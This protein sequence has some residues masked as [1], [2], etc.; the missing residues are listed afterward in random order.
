MA[1]LEWQEPLPGDPSIESPPQPTVANLSPSGEAGSYSAQLTAPDLE[2]YYALTGEVHL[3]G[4]K[5][6]TLIEMILVEVD[7]VEAG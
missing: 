7:P 3:P 5:P 6:L 4:A 2:G 1:T